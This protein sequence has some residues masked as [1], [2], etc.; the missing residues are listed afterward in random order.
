MGGPCAVAGAPVVDAESQYVIG[1]RQQDSLETSFPFVSALP[2]VE[3]RFWL[4]ALSV[5]AVPRAA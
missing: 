1:A 3:R 2:F 5:L 4:L